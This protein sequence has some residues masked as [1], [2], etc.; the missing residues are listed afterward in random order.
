VETDERKRQ[1][2][3]KAHKIGLR[4]LSS[5]PPAP[6]EIQYSGIPDPELA[7]R[8]DTID[9]TVDRLIANLEDPHGKK[10]SILAGPTGSGK[11]VWATYRMLKSSIGRDGRICV[12]QP[13]LITLRAK[14]DGKDDSTTPGFIARRLLQAPGFGAGHEVGFRYR[15]ESEQ[16]DRYTKLLF[17][18]D[19]LL[20]RWILSGEIGKFSVVMIDEAHEQSSNMELIFALL[21][22][23][24][25]L[26]PRLRVVI[27]SATMNV[28][29]FCKFFG[30]GDS[31]KVF[32]AS[33]DE[34]HNVTPH[35]IY[36]RFP[37]G[38]LSYLSGLPNF[39]VPEKPEEA[40]RAIAQIVE[41]IRMKDGFTKLGN[42]HGDI[43]AFLPT[44]KLVQDA[45]H[46]IRQ[47]RLPNLE[48]IPCYA[49]SPPE[50]F[51]LF[52][53]SERRAE[54]AFAE[55][56]PSS[57]QRVILATNYAETSVTLS[58][59]S[60]VIDS[61]WI[62]EP[63]W[64][65]ETS[66][67]DYPVRRHTTAGCTQRKGRV[68][69]VQ[70]GE[71]F[72]LY[73]FSAY[74]D[75]SVFRRAVIPEIARAPLDKFL[76]A[77][78]AAGIDDLSTFRWLGYDDTPAQKSE[79]ERAITALKQ[80]GTIDEDGD[81][82]ARGFELEGLEPK[83]VDHSLL[84]SESD[85]FGCTL[86]IATMLAFVSYGRKLF[87]DDEFELVNY[88]RWR[89]GCRDDLEFYL[90]IY[91]HWENAGQTADAKTHREWSRSNG[92]NHSVL[93]NIEKLR[94]DGLRPLTMRTHTEATERS[95]DL[96]RLHRVRFVIA[97][98]LWRWLYVS[99]NNSAG[100]LT[101]RPNYKACPCKR[102][103]AIDRDSSCVGDTDVGSM[104][105]LARELRGDTL[106]AK[107]IILIDPKWIPQLIVSGTAGSAVAVKNVSSQ[108]KVASAASRKA[109]EQLPY[110]QLV[111]NFTVGDA[112]NF[113]MVRG[114]P[115]DENSHRNRLLARI[116]MESG[117]R[118]APVF[119][120]VD[121]DSDLFPGTT[122]LAAVTSVNEQTKVVTVSRKDA[123]KKFRPGTSVTGTISKVLVD[124]Q[125]GV[126]YGFLVS[127]AAGINGRLLC[128]NF[129]R[130]YGFAPFWKVGSKISLVID[131][132]DN[133]Q[134]ELMPPT[135]NVE[136]GD[137]YNAIV[138]NF[139][140]GQFN[141]ARAGVFV[142]FRPFH[143]GFIHHSQISN[144]TLNS[145]DEGDAIVVSVLDITW[146][147]GKTKY[148]LRFDG[149]YRS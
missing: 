100:G 85:A 138:R 41:A 74:K 16:Q 139:L 145:L 65:P 115:P 53:R 128:R 148:D 48:A 91:S 119:L 118:T 38:K 61:G 124:E 122:F 114:N 80:A 2:A 28:D 20:I 1:Q 3:R 24:L 8:F 102:S 78:K 87:L 73:N 127:I 49:D 51:E 135:Y 6:N 42:P 27:A 90:R 134:I 116:E 95:L 112:Y 47:L 132:N 57:P 149:Y 133:G 110:Y 98:V 120:Q 106:F 117:G 55:G 13:R 97:R 58:N 111:T 7:R 29:R 34:A 77:A 62:M 32:V 86:E 26:Y 36:D 123:A 75:L 21:R 129:G 31:S 15:G 25:P 89:Q 35:P 12:S 17:V 39:R 9:P 70:P 40:P 43:L 18:T 137:C 72:R 88:D 71:V 33:P 136:V 64:N 59:L 23:K 113:I 126:R 37:D 81:L 5:N 94:K 83:F 10:V 105:C 142:E 22:Y 109:V 143:D 79:R 44:I 14:S 76:L 45:T 101:F 67:M 82:T 140:P 63:V 99:D 56:K 68:G 52:R 19:G 146:G 144:S 141:H 96:D 92:L 103:V 50:Q 84:L 4:K 11:S 30:N 130:S 60:Y 69:R 54:K 46:A 108:E 104:V 66:S 131:R 121:N 147:G 107:H 125:D 93:S